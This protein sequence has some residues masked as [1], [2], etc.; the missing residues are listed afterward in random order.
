MNLEFLKGIITYFFVK[1]KVIGFLIL[2][3]I[4]LLFIL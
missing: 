4:L 1:N 3:P 2:L